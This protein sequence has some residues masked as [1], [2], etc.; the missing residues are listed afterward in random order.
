MDFSFLF[1]SYSIKHL[2]GMLLTSFFLLGILGLSKMNKELPQS[3][4][5]LQLIAL[6]QFC[7]KAI[8]KPWTQREMQTYQMKTY[9]TDLK[10]TDTSISPSETRAEAG[11]DIGWGKIRDNR[12]NKNKPRGKNRD[13]GWENRQ[14]IWSQK[15]RKTKENCEQGITIQV[16]KVEKNNTHKEK[17]INFHINGRRASF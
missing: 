5:S 8:T 10:T 3:S 11:Q 14:N 15:K 9:N 16:Q 6:G 2:L 7:G 4:E 13:G 1:I 12:R 17:Q